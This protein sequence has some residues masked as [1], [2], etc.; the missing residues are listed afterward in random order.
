MSILI[1]RGTKVIVQG[2]TGKAARFH[3]AQMQADGTRIV[4]GTA[5]GKAGELCCGV[6]VFNTVRDAA[7]ATGARTSVIFVPAAF[8]A[9]AIMEAVEAEMD[10]VVCIT[11]HIP[12]EQMVRVHRYMEGKKTRLIGPNC[13]GLLCVDESNIGIIPAQIFKKGHVASFPVPAPSP[14]KPLSSSPRQVS[15]RPELSAS[16]ATRSK[17]LISS[18]Y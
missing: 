18:M 13:P 14:M 3:T 11:E 1:N 17:V 12:V 4:G 7:K 9:D 2:I 15:A 10:L 5:P 6:P 8:A 16:A